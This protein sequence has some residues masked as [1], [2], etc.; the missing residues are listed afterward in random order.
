MQNRDEH[1]TIVTQRYY[2]KREV[3]LAQMA[4]Y[5]NEHPCVDCGETDVRCLEFDHVRGKKS[6]NISAMLGRGISWEKVLVEIAKCDVRCANC[7]RRITAERGAH[8]RQDVH[9]RL[10]RDTHATALA[11]LEAVL[12]R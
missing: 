6:R 4:K 12:T 9:V 5:L 8:W 2:R 10:T 1:I 7:H 11:R 3:V